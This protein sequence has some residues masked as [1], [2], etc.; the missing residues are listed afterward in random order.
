MC[1]PGICGVLQPV[2][3]MQRLYVDLREVLLYD[4]H[5]GRQQRSRIGAAAEP[6]SN[7]M[8]A[9]P[10]LGLQQT[11]THQLF[12]MCVYLGDSHSDAGTLSAGIV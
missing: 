12:Y 11:F 6:Y 1:L 2:I 10:L 7:P 8:Q 3:D 5:R 9:L 4:F